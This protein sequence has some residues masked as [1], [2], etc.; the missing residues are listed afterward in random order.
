MIN[1][2]LVGKKIE[3]GGGEW[4]L[5]G[6]TNID[7]ATEN[8]IN[9]HK[10]TPDIHHDLN[11]GIPFPD[12]F[13]DEIFSSHCLEHLKDP[14]FILKECFRVCK[15]GSKVKFLV[16]KHDMSNK[17]HLTDMSEEW[18][19]KNVPRGLKIKKMET[20]SKTVKDNVWG[21]RTFDEITIE[22]AVEK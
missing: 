2:P 13:V 1:M 14:V 22:M 7:I 4:P 5:Q 21:D 12:N 18:F 10:F 19:E 8:P 9:G 17:T 15:N 16:P 20:K 11:E 6:F 3:L